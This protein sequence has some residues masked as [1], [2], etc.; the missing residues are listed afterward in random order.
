MKKILLL[1]SAFFL[2]V[3]STYAQTISYGINAGLNLTKAST[4]LNVPGLSEWNNYLTGFH[5]GAMVDIKFDAFSIQPG[6]LFTTKGG[7]QAIQAYTDDDAFL[8]PQTQKL[9][10]SY[11][12]IPLNILYSFKTSDGSFS[13]GGG[14]YAGFGLSAKISSNPTYD[15]SGEPQNYAV[16]FGGSGLKNLDFGLNGLIEYRLNS[17]P[18]ISAGYQYGLV[19]IYNGSDANGKNQGFSFSAGYFFK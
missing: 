7:K 8:G 9:T 17:G 4:T 12:E 14:P 3:T 11:L 13:L 5:V 2:A 10:L 1:S 19:N 15:N 18:F 16:G 6:V